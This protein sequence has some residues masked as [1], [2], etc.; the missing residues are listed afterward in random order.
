MNSGLEF[1]KMH[2]A[3]NDYVYV[4]TFSQEEPAIGW[5]ELA[6]RISNRNFGLGAD[7]LI[8]IEK[9]ISPNA[10]GRMTMFNADGSRSEMCG[11]GLRCVA[12]WLH[13]FQFCGQ[14][15]FKIDT[16]AG[17]LGVLVA[18]RDADGQA[19]QLTVNMGPPRLL[20]EDIPCQGLAGGKEECFNIAGHVLHYTAVGM[21][22]PHCVIFIE[23]DV[24][25]YP[26][27]DLGPLI[28]NNRA[29]FP[30]RVN[31]E[32]VQMLAKN[33]LVQRTWERGSGETLACGTGA[34]AVAVAAILNHHCE[35]DIRIH[36]RG[37]DLQLQWQGMGHPVLL[38][39]PAVLVASGFISAAL[40]R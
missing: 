20:A 8:L 23:G 2:G 16:G 3:G 29:L 12:K 5:P 34:S 4:P 35:K 26:V 9:A 14:K 31:V 38:T 27:T 28:E 13:D 1:F 21:G 24:Q 30:N 37:G 25:E 11:N 22:N 7:G 19:T 39:G 6:R 36:L 33:E 10:N 17:C 18:E 32:F 15:E 40:L